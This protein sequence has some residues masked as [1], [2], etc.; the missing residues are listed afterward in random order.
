MCTSLDDFQSFTSLGKPAA[1]AAAAATT[2]AVNPPAYNYDAAAPDSASLGRA[3]WTFLHSLAATY[4]ERATAAEQ[5][6]MASFLAILGNVY[7]CWYCAED[8]RGWMAGGEDAD[9]NK[10]NPNEPKLAGRDEFGDWMCR[11]HNAVNDKLG[12]P[13][14]DCAQWQRRWIRGWTKKQD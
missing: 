11:A 8:F 3:T 10:V 1:A 4:P 9:K 12:K 7:P 2:T 13:L 6:Q 5:R 14:F